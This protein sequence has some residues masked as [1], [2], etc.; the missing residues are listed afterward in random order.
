MARFVW[1]LI[2]MTLAGCAGSPSADKAGLETIRA[3]GKWLPKVADAERSAER[4][5]DNKANH[6][7]KILQNLGYTVSMAYGGNSCASRDDNRS[8]RCLS[9]GEISYSKSLE[10]AVRLTAPQPIDAGVEKENTAL[11]SQNICANQS[12]PYGWGVFRQFSTGQCG[13][14]YNGQRWI[15]YAMLSIVKLE[16][17]NHRVCDNRKFAIPSNYRISRR[18]I[19]GGQCGSWFNG[20]RWVLFN[21]MDLV[22][23]D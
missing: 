5:W 2:V 23:L 10:A 1:L 7:K 16:Q 14:W 13:S 11:Q 20:V 12:V 19:T 9:V 4:A 21:Q 8:F 22:K 15:P 3:Y 17:K 18:G 6:R